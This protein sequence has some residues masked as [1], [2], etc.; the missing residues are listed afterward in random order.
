MQ[1]GGLLGWRVPAETAS[2]VFPVATADK[3]IVIQYFKKWSFAIWQTRPGGA[4][5]NIGFVLLPASIQSTGKFKLR[6]SAM[7]RV[8]ATAEAGQVR[9]PGPLNRISVTQTGSLDTNVLFSFV[10]T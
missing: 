9:A 7:Y 2:G 3:K 5:A 8:E 6:G 4:V 10:W 1:P